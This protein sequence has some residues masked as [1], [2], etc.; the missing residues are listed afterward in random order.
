MQ[1]PLAFQGGAVADGSITETLFQSM[2]FAAIVKTSLKLN[3]DGRVGSETPQI[4][5]FPI[6]TFSKD[7][8]CVSAQ[9]SLALH[10]Q[11]PFLDAKSHIW[12]RSAPMKKEQEKDCSCVSVNLC[13]CS[14]TWRN[15]LCSSRPEETQWSPT[16]RWEG[17]NGTEA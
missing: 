4:H 2:S 17:E 11:L 9:D 12:F 13:K 10:E 16:E 15:M 6:G 3:I 1:H 7:P 8:L 5:V 14:A